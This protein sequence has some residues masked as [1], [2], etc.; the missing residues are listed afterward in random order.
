MYNAS[1]KRM[2][3]LLLAMMIVVSMFS[4]SA[5]NSKQEPSQNNTSSTKAAETAATQATPQATPE[6]GPF[7]KYEPA[8]EMTWVRDVDD[9][10]DKDL[11]TLKG[12]TGETLEKNRWLDV[13]EKELGIK[14][15]YNWIAK[16][17]SYNQK[18]TLA[19]A[20]G[21]LPDYF[22]CGGIQLK[23]LVESDMIHD[24]TGVWD[25]YAAP[26][27]KE[28]LEADGSAPFDA[29]TIGG[30]LY[31]IPQVMP[32]L[33]SYDYMW[34]RTDWL[35][36]L[37]LQ[38]PKT[39]ADLLKISSAFTNNDPDGNGK[40]DTYGFF[41]Y[42]GLWYNLKGFFAAYH[43]YPEA[44]IKDA[45]GKLGYGS[46]QPEM[47]SALKDIAAMYKDGQ[48]DK[49]F[50]VKDCAKE[51]ELLASGKIGIMFGG[52]WESA[53]YMQQLKIKDP[54][55]SW[56]CYPIPSVDGQPAREFLN[57]STSSWVVAR[58]EA[59][60]PEAVIKLFNMYA[61]KLYGKTSDYGVYGNAEI[62][63]IWKMP[64]IHFHHPHVNL[65]AF[66]EIEESRKNNT[67]DQLKGVAKEYYGN[68]ANYEVNKDVKFWG[69]ERMFASKDSPFKVIDDV[70]N[71]KQ[72]FMNE[73]YGVPTP[74]AVEK[75]ATLKEL[76]D[77]TV[78]KIILGKLEVDAGFD[79]F[80]EDWKKL[81]GDKITEEVNQ[82]KA[83]I[84]K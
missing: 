35:E 17:E 49:E 5:C 82:W 68:I 28:I 10:F 7:G 76:Q 19:M 14:I 48:I 26:V 81:G 8:I 22:W 79:K 29:G 25:K 64:P 6:D 12:K 16:G 32:T 55:S 73:F 36:K 77:S 2:L 9:Y 80:V 43:A 18:F 44:W 4:L 37:G 3:H 31:G 50:G 46:I 33:D 47:K 1:F 78:T 23:Q 66:R 30:K 75:A 61:E 57:M 56:S 40:K 60:H 41:L 72:Y 58:K 24:L 63:G 39:T 67:L 53:G 42:N 38:P 52:H 51:G 54:A 45:S 13:F 20:S 69:W 27:T 15:K 59:K 62:D 34:I 21:D 11:Q 83:E 84:G 71:N 74:T 65:I 70:V